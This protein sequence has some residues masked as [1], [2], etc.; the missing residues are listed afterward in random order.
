MSGADDIDAFR[1][2]FTLA[3]ID[4]KII[5]PAL[6]IVGELWEQGNISVAE[7]HL[8]GAVCLSATM[9]VP[10]AEVDLLIQTVQLSRPHAAFVVGGRGFAASLRGR[11]S[12]SVTA[13][14]RSSKRSTPPFSARSSTDLHAAGV[15]RLVH[16]AARLGDGGVVRRTATCRA[17]ARAR[18]RST[19]RRRRTSAAPR[20]RR[21]RAGP[22]ARCSIRS[23][24]GMPSQSHS[25]RRCASGSPQ[26]VAC[27]DDR[28]VDAV[29]VPQV[30]QPPCW[31]SPMSSGSQD[32]RERT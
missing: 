19:P 29:L 22:P 15:Q 28:H 13:S 17:G 1:R 9:P 16:R 26:E 6:Y 3:L 32:S 21:T 31:G 24:N 2:A 5:A 20:R 23:V 8:A 30:Q 7:E 14:P 25:Q 12:R 27:V 4:D 11:A 18:S 10:A